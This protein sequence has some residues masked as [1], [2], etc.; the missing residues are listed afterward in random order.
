MYQQPDR[1]LQTCSLQGQTLQLSILSCAE[2]KTR[3][4][5]SNNN[6]YLFD[7]QNLLFSEKLLKN[8]LSINH[9]QKFST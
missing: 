6:S 5:F 8:I 9:N 7:E 1:Y 2:E 4:A 3:T